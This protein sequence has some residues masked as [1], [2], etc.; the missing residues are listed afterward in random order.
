MFPSHGAIEA[1]VLRHNLGELH[2]L[3]SYISRILHMWIPESNTTVMVFS[4][5]LDVFLHLLIRVLCPRPRSY[6]WSSHSIQ[7]WC[8]RSWWALNS[9][10]TYKQLFSLLTKAAHS[11]R[12]SEMV[13]EVARQLLTWSH[14]WSDPILTLPSTHKPRNYYKQ[15]SQWE[16]PRFVPCGSCNV[17]EV[18]KP[19]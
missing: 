1:H 10:P 5:T 17:K 11:M 14:P 7:I 2:L 6:P 3:R 16:C 8:S 19:Q 12:R 4:V 9:I 15:V 13:P 18:S